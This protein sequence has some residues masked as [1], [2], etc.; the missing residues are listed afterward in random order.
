VRELRALARRG[1]GS[2]V[3]GRF[4]RRNAN[5]LSAGLPKDL[6]SHFL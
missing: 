3:H 2:V 1:W 6:L 5:N 4:D